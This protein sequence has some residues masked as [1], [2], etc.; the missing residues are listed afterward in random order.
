MEKVAN[1]SQYGRV[2]C[3]YTNCGKPVVSTHRLVSIAW[4]VKYNKSRSNRGHSDSKKKDSHR[5]SR[6]RA[7]VIDRPQASNSKRVKPAFSASKITY[8]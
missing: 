2:T 7:A 8:P 1:S 4:K 3:P 5:T 6:K